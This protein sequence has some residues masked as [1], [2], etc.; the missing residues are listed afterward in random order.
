MDQFPKLETTRLILDKVQLADIPKI[1]SYAN[2]SKITENTRTLPYPYLEEDAVSWI[3][4]I[5]QGFKNKDN[6]IF[7][8]RKK[9]DDAFIGGIG[10]TLDV[11]NNRAELG[12][13]TAEPFWNKGYTTEG[14]KAILSFGFETLKLNKIIAIYL[15]ANEASGKVMIKNGMV[16]EAE[17]IDHDIKRGHTIED[18]VYVS[19]VQY[20]LTKTEY[21]SLNK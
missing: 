8:L 10:L 16:K 19:L 11:Q 7:A 9:L 4:M 2:N 13:W 3:H 20:R 18:P 12:Y 1:V 17:F 5:N 15:T 14:V 6:F 21:Q